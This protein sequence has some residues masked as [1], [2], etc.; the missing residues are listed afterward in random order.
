LKDLGFKKRERLGHSKLTHVFI[1]A[2]I[3]DRQAKAIGLCGHADDQPPSRNGKPESQKTEKN[4]FPVVTFDYDSKRDSI[5]RTSA[6]KE[7]VKPE[8]DFDKIM[9]VK[10]K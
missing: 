7:S 3:L 6:K 2:K 8:T 1:N 4:S 5:V 9:G 10:K